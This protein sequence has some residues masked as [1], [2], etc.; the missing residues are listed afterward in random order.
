M[1]TRRLVFIA[2]PMAVG[3][4]TLISRLMAGELEM[5]RRQ[6]GLDAA[7]EWHVLDKAELPMLRAEST[8]RKIL[9]H[10]DIL[11]STTDPAFSEAVEPFVGAEEFRVV[12]LWAAPATLQKRIVEREFHGRHPAPSQRSNWHRWSRSARRLPRWLRNYLGTRFDR[13]ES[14]LSHLMRRTLGITPVEPVF[15]ALERY[16]DPASVRA[17]YESWRRLCAARGVEQ[18][19]I[20]TTDGSY[21]FVEHPPWHAAET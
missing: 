20:D 12:T 11:H 2:G 18:I 3:K 21:R 6:L 5:F 1:A 7:D 13:R 19:F 9:C 8:A 14:W 17:L 15:Q 4:T 10:F 16:R